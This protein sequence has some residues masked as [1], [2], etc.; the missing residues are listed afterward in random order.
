MIYDRRVIEEI[1][2]KN[3]Y[4]KE[5]AETI[6]KMCEY[7][8][9]KQLWGACHACSSVLYVIFTEMGYNTT[10][11]VGEVDTNDYLFDHSW[12]EI[13]NKI[14]DLAINM[15]LDDGKSANSPIILGIDSETKQQTT[16]KYGVQ[17]IGFDEQTKL[18]LQMPFNEYMDNFPW[19]DRGLWGVIEEVTNKTIDI[20]EFRKKYK[21][22]V[23]EI[24]KKS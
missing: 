18:L 2:L 19:N 6:I 13:D 15:T 8:N 12:I 3:G 4:K 21:D 23:R 9:E 20:K 11:C 22:T 24:I 10:I 14:I 16:I 17:G 1:V 7:L 5:I